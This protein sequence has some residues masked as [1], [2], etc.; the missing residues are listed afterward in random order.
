MNPIPKDQLLSKLLDGVKGCQSR[1]GSRTE[2][3]TE[4]EETVRKLCIAFEDVFLHGA[5]L[6]EKGRSLWQM[7]EN[8][9]QLSKHD[10]ER[11]LLLHNVRTDHGRARA[12]LRSSL[13]E[14]SL[15]R[16]ILIILSLDTLP[17]YYE[18]W[19]FL[20]DPELSTI[21]PH[22]AAGLGS[23]LFALVVDNPLLDCWVRPT[24]SK[25]DAVASPVEVAEVADQFLAALK[26]DQ[27]A[28]AD[29]STTPNQRRPNLSLGKK[30][31]K[32]HVNVVS[33]DDDGNNDAATKKSTTSTTPSKT[34]DDRN[35]TSPP[36]HHSSS[37]STATTPTPTPTTPTPHKLVNSAT[38]PVQIIASRT[39]SSAST[40]CGLQSHQNYLEDSSL[41]EISVY[42]SSVKSADC[43]SVNSIYS[44]CSERVDLENVMTMGVGGDLS[45]GNISPS[46]RLKPVRD[47]AGTSGRDDG[48]SSSGGGGGTG[49]TGT[50]SDPNNDSSSQDLNLIPV[51]NFDPETS[52][53]VA[54][55]LQIDLDMSAAAADLSP[56]PGATTPSYASE[57]VSSSRTHR[58]HSGK[59]PVSNIYDHICSLSFI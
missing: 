24:I 45:F 39:P 23:V 13:N 25:E 38:S 41:P 47:R 42:S 18:T 17:S 16:Y 11:F 55:E 46:Q 6:P 44:D 15:E 50:D 54:P 57:P 30:K 5:K 4:D 58:H 27:A 32:P 49:G 2:L 56:S 35:S 51:P 37:T 20:R 31:K 10:A 34:H 19:A 3:A 59:G 43:I 22:T 52:R 8:F 48:G 33:F 28:A 36:Q 9:S 26:K 21:L 1:F 12:W 53:R 7:T 14:H 40:S 29:C